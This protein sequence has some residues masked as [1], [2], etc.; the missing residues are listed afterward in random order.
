MN[1]AESLVR[2][3]LATGIDTCFAN[4]GTSEMH[5]VAALDRFPA[6][7]CILGLHET[8]VTGAADGYGRIAEKPAATLLHLGPGLA[9]GLA[10]L[11]NARR[12][13]SP[14]VNII[15]DHA[16]YHVAYDAPLASDIVS[17]AKPMSHWVHSSPDSRQIAGDAARAVQAARTAPGQIASLILPADTAWGE[18]D[19]PAD[20]LPIPAPSLPDTDAIAE[21]VRWLRSGR[22]VGL[23]IG[24]RA[25]MEDGLSLAGR[26][27]AHTGAE[28]LAPTSVRRIQRGAGRVG[29]DRVPYP[30]DM[31]VKRLAHLEALILVG[32]AAP[33]AFF[34]YPGKPSTLAPPDAAIIPVA[35]PGDDLI[36]ALTALAE[37]TGALATPVP[38]R[39]YTPTAAPTGPI[40]PDTAAAAVA[41]TL[42]DDAII[43][44]E[45]LT[46][47]RAMAPQTADTHPHDWIQ[48][49]GGAIGCGMPLAL[50]ASI[51]APGRPVLCLQ[52]D[53]SGLYSLQALWTMAREATPV[54]V[55]IFNN[56]AYRILQGEMTN[57]GVQN[58][59]RVF[60]DLFQLDRP[61]IDWVLLARGFGVPGERV[62]T[63]EA[64]TTALA[65]GFASRGPYLVEALI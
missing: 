52:A 35:A 59:G 46:S 50:G 10:N 48:I 15:G 61:T 38:V 63:A 23:L 32:A 6:M 62:E 26:I 13:R 3:L 43:A 55:L 12:A 57:V 9:N 27:V 21:A 18:A 8:V 16:T 40:T 37:A 56:R 49:T 25:L 41:A 4:P 45:G 60:T 1:G 22:K 36:A 29:L 17:L 31:A 47:S 58:P 7:R 28:L 33:V 11:H 64:L 53:G 54:V 24:D 39:P 19:G 44:D 2:T 65:R 14:I 20:A 51:A 42:P 30:V 34:A 5:F